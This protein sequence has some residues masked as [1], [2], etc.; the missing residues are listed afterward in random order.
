M[1]AA[2]ERLVQH[3]EENERRVNDIGR[4]EQQWETTAMC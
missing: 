1:N 2:Y 3:L 4:E